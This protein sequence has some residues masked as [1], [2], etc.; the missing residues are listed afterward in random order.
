MEGSLSTYRL[1]KLILRDDGCELRSENFGTES[2]HSRLREELLS[3]EIFEDLKDARR[4]ISEKV[5]WY[6]TER[7]H[8]LL[9]YQAPLEVFNK[10]GMG[11]VQQKDIS[12]FPNPIPYLLKKYPSRAF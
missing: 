2:F 8:S 5:E 1:P 12:A 4:K 6:N 10:R 3:A 11:S 7:P 9:G